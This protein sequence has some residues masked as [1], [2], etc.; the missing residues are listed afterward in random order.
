MGD[1]G[2]CRRYDPGRFCVQLSS[3]LSYFRCVQSV[4]ALILHPK[5][6]DSWPGVDDRGDP[7]RPSLDLLHPCDSDQMKMTLADPAV[8]M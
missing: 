2:A 8:G 5:D 7:R 4:L 3:R 1:G 6:Y